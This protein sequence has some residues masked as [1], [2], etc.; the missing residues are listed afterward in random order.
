MVIIMQKANSILFVSEF[1]L[2]QETSGCLHLL[3]M[4][5]SVQEV[6]EVEFM[7]L[8]HSI[9]SDSGIRRSTVLH[10]KYNCKIVAEADN[11]HI[12]ADPL[13][14]LSA[15]D[16]TRYNCFLTGMMFKEAIENQ[17]SCIAIFLQNPLSIFFCEALIKLQIKVV[18]IVMDLPE[19][20]H[21]FFKNDSATAERIDSAFDFVLTNARGILS[22]SQDATETILGVSGSKNVH[23]VYPKVRSRSDLNNRVNF[24]A[25]YTQSPIRETSIV[26]AGQIYAP[27]CLKAFLI[28]LNKLAGRSKN[29]SFVFHYFGANDLMNLISNE[30]MSEITIRVSGHMPHREV[31]EHIRRATFGY[32]CYPFI[33]ELSQTTKF[34]FPSKFVSYIEGGLFPLFH[35]PLE[36]TV[37]NFLSSHNLQSLILDTLNQES[38]EF[39]LEVLFDDAQPS[40]S[41]SDWERI[42][43]HFNQTTFTDVIRSMLDRV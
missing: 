14:R 15:L 9:E 27:E 12:Y 4:Y 38:L 32:V 34:S 28:A 6:C 17:Y 41:Y 7:T 3:D 2:M 8:S 10:E 42:S 16:K 19:M 18:A 23:T 39:K 30:N 11:P 24:D 20:R 25:K 40:L 21:Y 35:G 1:P 43:T 33:E 5:L 37:G 36:S 26:L 29:K 31:Q 22:P 13:Q